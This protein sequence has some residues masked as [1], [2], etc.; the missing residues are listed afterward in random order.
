MP[1]SQGIEAEIVSLELR[2]SESREVRRVAVVRVAGH[3]LRVFV[4]ERVVSAGER[5]RIAIEGECEP[6][7]G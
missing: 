4:R 6:V 7:E 3:L 5:V 2:P 1:D